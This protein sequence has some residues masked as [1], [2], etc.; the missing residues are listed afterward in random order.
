M[1]GRFSFATTVNLKLLVGGAG[2]KYAFNAGSGGGGGSFVV[3]GSTPLVVAGGGSG[4][5]N[6][7][8]NGTPGLTTTSGDYSG[9]GNPGGSNGSGGS[10]FGPGGGGGGGG[11]SGDGSNNPGGG[12]GGGISFL[13]GGAGGGPN[14]YGG[15]GGYGGG[16]GGG[17]VGSGGG[18]GYSGGGGGDGSP[19]GGGG[20]IIDS[21]AVAI[22]DAVP[23]VA[24][25]D[26]SPAGEIIITAVPQLILLTSPSA[27]GGNFGFDISGPFNASIVVEACTNLTN[28]VWIP[29]VTNVL[30]NGTNH[31]SDPNWANS[32]NSFYRV[33]KP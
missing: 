24:S 3:R 27:A 33:S 30:S 16:G 12:G 14:G 4:A 9:N 18:G 7:L 21:S 19:G 23:G 15:W 13:N 10:T 25:P 29:V 22:I 32:P 5:Y 8:R 28:P 6:Y 26:G 2:A 11:Y 17:G 20:S 1:A 31:F